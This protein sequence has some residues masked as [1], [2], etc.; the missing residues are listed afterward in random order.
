MVNELISKQFVELIINNLENNKRYESEGIFINKGSYMGVD[1]VVVENSDNLSGKI[2]TL[3]DIYV[4]LLVEY[5]E[6]SE[7]TK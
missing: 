4:S 7:K 6:Y 2:Q 5:I 1:V 3:K